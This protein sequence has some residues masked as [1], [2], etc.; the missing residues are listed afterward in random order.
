MDA[1]FKPVVNGEL[2]TQN[3]MKFDEV[4]M[5]IR[6]LKDYYHCKYALVSSSDSSLIRW[7]VQNQ[8]EQDLDRHGRYQDSHKTI[9]YILYDDSCSLLYR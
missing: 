4:R 8:Q 3:F 5:N 6:N 1:A 7:S 9:L 2:D